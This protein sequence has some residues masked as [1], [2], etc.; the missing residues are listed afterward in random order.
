MAR[1][2]PIVSTSGL[3]RS[4]GS[5]SQAGRTTTG[6]PTTDDAAGD[7]AR[8]VRAAPSRPRWR[9]EAGEVVADAIRIEP[10]CGDHEQRCAL[11][12]G[13]QGR[14][15]DHGLAASGTATVASAAPMT[16][17]RTGIGRAAG[18][19]VRPGRRPVQERWCARRWSSS[20]G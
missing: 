4:K 17:A 8:L 1:R 12:E 19:A 10:R 11:G 14:R 13:R 5:V 16:A 9:K 6:P 15:D 18:A 7:V 3:T 2:R 20:V